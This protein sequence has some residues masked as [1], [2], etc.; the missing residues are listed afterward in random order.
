VGTSVLFALRT[1]APAPVWLLPPLIGAAV[2]VYRGE[3]ARLMANHP[4][5]PSTFSRTIYPIAMVLICFFGCAFIAIGILGL[6][7]ALTG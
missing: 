2:L 1:D 4:L 5:F 7:A 6:I 3:L